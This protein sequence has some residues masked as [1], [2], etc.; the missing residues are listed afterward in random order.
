M[1]FKNKWKILTFVPILYR[2]I[3]VW[4]SK[5]MFYEVIESKKTKFTCSF[6]FFLS[7][8]WPEVCL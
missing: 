7:Q 8:P 4:G 6:F 3:R 2:A 1:I 5:E